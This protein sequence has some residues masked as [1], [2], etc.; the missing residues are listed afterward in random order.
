MALALG[1]SVAVGREAGAQG[2]QPPAGEK[3][4]AKS[5]S[6]KDT[7]TGLNEGLNAFD[8][9]L[10]TALHNAKDGANK[11]LEAVDDGVHKALK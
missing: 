5:D 2:R 8:K 4:K 10:H 6:V 3:K 1:L 7:K 9:D 11:A